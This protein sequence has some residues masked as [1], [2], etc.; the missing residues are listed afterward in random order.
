MQPLAETGL[1]FCGDWETHAKIHVE[2]QGTLNNQK[3][4]NLEKEQS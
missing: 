2:V 3:K 1:A 4:K